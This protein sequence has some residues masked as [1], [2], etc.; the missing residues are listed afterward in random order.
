MDVPQF[1]TTEIAVVI[2]GVA[3]LQHLAMTDDDPD[4][5]PKEIRDWGENDFDALI[6]KLVRRLAE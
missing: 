4:N 2:A 5:M 6:G 3:T 1:T